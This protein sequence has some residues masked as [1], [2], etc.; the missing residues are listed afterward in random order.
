MEDQAPYV[1]ATAATPA[2]LVPYAAA[3]QAEGFNVENWA[4][5]NYLCLYSTW[6]PAPGVCYLCDLVVV[7]GEVRA[8][9]LRNQADAPS[10]R[11]FDWMRVDT[12]EEL[13]WLLQ[14]TVGLTEARATP[15][16][17]AAASV[18]PPARP[19]GSAGP[20]QHH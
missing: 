4:P 11:L 12:T 8:W 3:L 6:Q 18:P 7:A 14:R 20:S 2:A 15:A 1:A 10:F 16:A 19:A 5:G 17:A 13:R 9:L